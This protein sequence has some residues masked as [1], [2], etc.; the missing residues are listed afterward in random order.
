MLLLSLQ[1]LECHTIQGRQDMRRKLTF[2]VRLKPGLHGIIDHWEEVVHKQE[3]NSNISGSIFV[4]CIG[5]R[6]QAHLFSLQLA[7]VGP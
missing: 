3:N 1:R 6:T 2:F 7:H 4:N 5:T